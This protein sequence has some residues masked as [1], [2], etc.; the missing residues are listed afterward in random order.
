MPAGLQPDADEP[1]ATSTGNPAAEQA[2]ACAHLSARISRTHFGGS[3]VKAPAEH[4]LPVQ[5]RAEHQL[6]VDLWS[7][8]GRKPGKD[9]IKL[10]LRDFNQCAIAQIQEFKLL[11]QDI[12]FDEMLFPKDLGQLQKFIKG[13]DRSNEQR[14]ARLYSNVSRD[15]AAHTTSE[16]PSPSPFPSQGGM[17]LQP[18][19]VPTPQSPEMANPEAPPWPPAS[20]HRSS[21]VEHVS[22]TAPNSGDGDVIHHEEPPADRKR[23]RREHAEAAKLRAQ[24]RRHEA[25]S[26]TSVKASIAHQPKPADAGLQPQQH[27]VN[28]RGGK[29]TA[30]LCRWCGLPKIG[31]A[32]SGCQHV[33]RDAAGEAIVDESKAPRPDAAIKEGLP[34]YKLNAAGLERQK[35]LYGSP[36]AEL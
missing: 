23:K 27:Q 17:S 8:H 34:F 15:L 6:L 3:R 31:H 16:H 20:T 1:A 21:P 29:G 14:Q 30:K 33:E 28:A 35:T 2:S 22:A 7:Q 4:R 13:L 19:P 36:Q 25:S 10:V 5:T 32:K 24:R 26:A 11:Q 9:K 12:P 18:G